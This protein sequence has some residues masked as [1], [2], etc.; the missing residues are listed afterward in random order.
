MRVYTVFFVWL[1][2][3][4][5]AYTLPPKICLHMIVCNQERTVYRSLESVKGFVDCISICDVGSADGTIH[6]IEEF[7]KN[8]GI[9]GVIHQA[10][11]WPDVHSPFS[12]YIAQK[13]IKD[14]GFPLANCYIFTMDATQ[15]ADFKSSFTKESLQEES[16][17]ILEKA[18]YLG[19]EKYM[20]HLFRASLSRNLDQYTPEFS[21]KLTS[22]T[23]KEIDDGMQAVQLENKILLWTKAL[24][25]DPQNFRYHLWIAE[26][27]LT[28]G[29]YDDAIQGF[30]SR[31]EKGG[32]PEEIWLSK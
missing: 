9:P 14:L 31:I 16:Y 15:I 5:L 7:F 8:S 3:P 4:L 10:E 11:K 19:H 32:D 12:M 25:Q 6:V 18:M 20:P 24:A 22:L 30:L 2:F 28:L 1:F 23:I 29:H 13:T 17:A 21:T 26:A 27:H